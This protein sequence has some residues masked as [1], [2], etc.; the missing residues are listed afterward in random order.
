MS[1]WLPAVGFV[2]LALGCGGSKAPPTTSGPIA[3]STAAAEDEEISPAAKAA[4]ASA[5][6]SPPVTSADGSI[7]LELLVK[8]GDGASEFPMASAKDAECTKG[9]GYTG[10]SDKDYEALTGKCGAPTGLKGYAKKVTGK[11]DE[12]H[13]RDVYTFKMAGGFCYRFFAVADDTVDNLDIRVQ[14]PEGGLVSIAA[15][16]NFVAIMDP[17]R[18]W[19]KTHDREFRLVVET[20]SGHGSYSFGVWARPKEK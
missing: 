16:K 17:D 13:L 1:A 11:L 14:R 15:S 20:S 12:K 4:V 9:I 6:A 3:S 8:P 19:C 2:L 7:I 18:V 5:S 10:K